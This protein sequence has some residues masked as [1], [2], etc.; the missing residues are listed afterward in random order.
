MQRRPYRSILYV[1]A[2]KPEWMAK[3]TKF[4][5]DAYVLDLEDAVVE[6]SKPA[7]R[8]MAR[9]AIPGLAAQGVG[10]FVRI[11]GI[12]TPHWFEDIRSVAVGGLTGIIPPKV[13]SAT[14]VAAMSL[15]LD[16][17]E[18]PAGIEPGSIDIQILFETAPG[19]ENAFEIIRAS[20]RV[21]SFFGGVARDG[22]VNRTIGLRWTKEGRESLYLRSK[23][24]LAGRAAGVPYP[25]SGTWI[26]LDDLDGL[27]EYAVECRNLGYTGMYVIHPS[28]VEIANEVFT[29]TAD[30][31]DRARRIVAEIDRAEQ[32]GLGAVRFEGAMIDIAMAAGSREVLAFVDELNSGA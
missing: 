7:A 20:P 5:A 2:D 13:S 31:V 6:E 17:L 15:I 24:L 30:E 1:P 16:A 27:R 28:H 23:L 11:N 18:P 4:G 12:E 19:I 26:D 14:E 22:D 21:R 9:E 29:P 8:G 25:V 3:A 32:E 10:V